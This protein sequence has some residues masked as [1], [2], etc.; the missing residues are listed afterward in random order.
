MML[1]G[2]RVARSATEAPVRDL[3]VRRGRVSFALHGPSRRTWALDLH[4]YLILPG[5]INAHDHLEFNLFPRLGRGPYPN[6]SAWARDIYH[7]DHDPI[8]QHLQ[9]SKEIRLLWGGLKNLLSGV[10]TVAHHNPYDPAVFDKSFPVRVVKRFGWAHSLDFTSDLLERYR[11]T[12][13]RWPFILHAAEGTDRCAHDEICR[14]HE[15]G[16]LGSRTVLVHAVG[17]DRDGRELLR[18]RRASI[19]WCPSSNR[20]TLGCTLELEFLRSGVPVALGTDSALTCTGDLAGEIQAARRQSLRPEEVYEM[21]M[22]QPA[23]ILRLRS[24]EGSLRHGGVADLVVVRDHGQTPAA[25]LS[26][27]RPELVLVGGHVKLASDVMAA[28]LPQAMRDQLMPI[29][30]EGRGRWL[31]AVDTRGLFAKT[32]AILGDRVRLAG[33]SV[34]I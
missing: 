3:L 15:S 33:W 17:V 2:A 21:V 10:T 20:F 12:P 26:E 4:G 6:A 25:A 22:R 7:P 9:V 18:R 27:L 5:L 28:R 11:R 13:L 23:R 16:V 8:R 1:T 31:V 14:L 34:R 19:V 32:S 24:G 30:L 29:E